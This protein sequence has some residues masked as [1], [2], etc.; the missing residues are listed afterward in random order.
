[1]QNVSVIEG[2]DFTNPDDIEKKFATIIKTH[3]EGSLQHVFLCH[4]KPGISKKQECELEES[5]M[6]NVRSNM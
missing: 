5:L 4:Q 6:V 3:L 2:F 1:M